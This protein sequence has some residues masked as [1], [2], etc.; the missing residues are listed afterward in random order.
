MALFVAVAVEMV[1]GE[2]AVAEILPATPRRT[3]CKNGLQVQGGNDSWGIARVRAS[4]S[5]V[6]RDGPDD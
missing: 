3:H 2:T 6:G 1:G 4:F 5:I